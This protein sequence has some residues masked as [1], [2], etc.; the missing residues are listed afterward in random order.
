MDTYGPTEA[1]VVATL[2]DL[3]TMSATAPTWREVPI[4][5]AV[6]NVQTYVLD[7]HGQPLPI[8]VPG[9]LYLGGA[10]LARGYGKRP[11]LTA[12]RFAPHPF[13]AKPGARLYQTGDRVCYRRDGSLAFLG[14]LDEQIKLRGFR[15]ELGEIEAILE[16]HRVVRQALVVGREAEP[17]ET[18]LV[19]YIVP[20]PDCEVME[21]RRFLEEKLPAYMLPSAFVMLPAFPLMSTGKVDRRALPAPD[22][23]RPAPDDAFMPPGTPVETVLVDIWA[24]VLRLEAVGTADNFF[25][26]GGHSLM[27]AQVIS[28]LR[29]A[30]E[31]E[32]SLRCLFE[33]PTIAELAVEI[34]AR[35]TAEIDQ[36]TDDEAWQRLHGE[37]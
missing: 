14:R 11:A 33:R 7:R 13:S 27:A 15:I 35:L 20:E 8:G 25:A 36:L 30:F 18:R 12:E 24:E 9:E 3:S 26:L 4:G 29:S 6:G 31:V 1:T 17:G 21:L 23:K 5:Q 19:A 32:I 16:Q 2:A 22:R 37:G 34:E 10:G 28:R